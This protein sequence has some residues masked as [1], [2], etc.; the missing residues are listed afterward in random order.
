ME[1]ATQIPACILSKASEQPSE[2]TSKE[3]DNNRLTIWKPIHTGEHADRLGQCSL[4]SSDKS[5][6]ASSIRPL[7]IAESSTTLASSRSTE[8]L[9]LDAET[10]HKSDEE[11]KVTT[12]PDIL[13][14]PSAKVVRTVPHPDMFVIRRT[15]R[16]DCYCKCHGVEPR[17]TR[18][19]HGRS[20]GQKIPCT[21]AFCLT[22]KDTYERSESRGQD[23]VMTFIRALSAL[24]F[25]KSIRAPCNL[26]SYRMIP[27]GADVIRYV[28]HGNFDMVKACMASG[29]ATI[30]DTAPDGWSL[31]HVRQQQLRVSAR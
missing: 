14:S 26:K 11:L 28:K 5:S 22:N 19:R 20:I 29:E 2:D 6:T 16:Y 30:W 9:L 25:T 4:R 13:P 18:K 23:H 17:D 3:Y 31:L 21:D 10:K 27:E 7:S 24:H 12:T 1:L 15:C 8:S